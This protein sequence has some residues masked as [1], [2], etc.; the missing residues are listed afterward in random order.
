M[1]N[2]KYQIIR[3]WLLQNKGFSLVEVIAGILMLTFFALGSLQAIGIATQIRAASERRDRANNWIQQN[4]EQAKF[5]ASGWQEGDA[6]EDFTE[7]N[8]DGTD[9]WTYADDGDP[10]WNNNSLC[11][12]VNPTNQGDGFGALLEAFLESPNGYD[13]NPDNTTTIGDTN[14]NQIGNDNFLGRDVQLFYQPQISNENPFN[15]LQL[16]YIVINDEDGNLTEDDI[17]ARIDTEIIPD[18]AFQC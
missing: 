15:T 6:F 11:G 5:W 10:S 14:Y 7:S 13:Y 17:I 16:T 8:A 18:A 12:S 9:F 1:N 3:Q 4:I 2:L